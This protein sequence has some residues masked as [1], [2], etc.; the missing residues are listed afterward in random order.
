M[1]NPGFAVSCKRYFT[2]NTGIKYSQEGWFDVIPHVLNR[3]LYVVVFHEEVLEVNFITSFNHEMVFQGV[4]NEY[5]Q[6][7]IIS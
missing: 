6:H 4:S 1:R 7:T 2:R 3:T 5:T